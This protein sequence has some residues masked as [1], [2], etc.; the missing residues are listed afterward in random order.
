MLLGPYKTNKNKNTKLM[1]NINLTPASCTFTTKSGKTVNCKPIFEGIANQVG[2]YAIKG[3]QDMPIE[4]LEDLRQDAFLKSLTSFESFD[5]ERP[6]GCPQAYGARISCNLERDAFRKGNA[7]KARFTSLEYLQER[8]A[9]SKENTRKGRF[10][11]LDGYGE[12]PGPDSMLESRETVS[13]VLRKLSKMGENHRMIL[14]MARQ[15]CTAEE[16]AETLGC[17]LNAVYIR[18]HKARKAFAAALGQEF[19]SRYGYRLGA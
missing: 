17:S 3:G 14:D 9:R 11:N 16:I 18:L 8:D 6:N 2:A 12:A 13:F 10:S 15:G 19:M 1:K 7:R 4:D 5:P